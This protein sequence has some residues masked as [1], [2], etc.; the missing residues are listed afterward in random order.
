MIQFTKDG[1]L[2]RTNMERLRDERDQ[3][4][5]TIA[6]TDDDLQELLDQNAKLQIAVA[7][8]EG[9][10]NDLTMQGLQNKFLAEFQSLKQNPILA[11]P[12]VISPKETEA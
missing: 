2:I 11:E 3:I 8:M 6:S 1:K 12:I 4:A 10:A 5:E 9:A 7:E